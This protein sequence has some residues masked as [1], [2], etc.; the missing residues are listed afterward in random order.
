MRKQYKLKFV[1][2]YLNPQSQYQQETENIFPDEYGNMYLKE[3]NRVTRLVPAFKEENSPAVVWSK[4]IK[5]LNIDIENPD[6]ILERRVE[7][8]YSYRK[9]DFWNQVSIDQVLFDLNNRAYIFLDGKI[10]KL[11]SR[12]MNYYFINDVKIGNKY[13]IERLLGIE[14]ND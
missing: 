10:Q 12:D 9:D 11:N 4:K 1:K 8:E 13:F 3:G 2:I 6:F 14:L 7:R 5:E